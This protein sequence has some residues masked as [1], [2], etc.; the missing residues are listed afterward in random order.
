[1]NIKEVRLKALVSSIAH[2]YVELSQN[3]VR[4]QRDDQIKRCIKLLEEL[5]PREIEQSGELN[6]EF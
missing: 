3:K 2:S 1:M 6:D 5:Y 4:W